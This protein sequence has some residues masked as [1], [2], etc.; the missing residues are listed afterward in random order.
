MR[1]KHQIDLL[2]RPDTHTRASPDAHDDG[3]PEYVPHSPEDG[4]D[5]TRGG[6]H[7]R[8]KLQ[9]VSDT[10]NTYPF[11]TTRRIGLNGNSLGSIAH[12]PLPLTCPFTPITP[13][14][15]TGVRVIPRQSRL[16]RPDG[17]QPTYATHAPRG[18]LS[19]TPRL[20]AVKQHRREP[21]LDILE[22][23]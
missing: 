2:L 13:D 7:T 5:D 11:A 21:V 16:I 22:S 8:A 3:G 14:A 19:P 17:S 18:H 6:R 12:G 10:H 9:L 1:F 15:R 23:I 20:L 4:D